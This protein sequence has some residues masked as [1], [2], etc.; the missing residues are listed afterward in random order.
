MWH[1]TTIVFAN[2]YHCITTLKYD[3]FGTDLRQ[4]VVTLPYCNC[5]AFITEKQSCST[6]IHVCKQ[7]CVYLGLSHDVYTS[8]C[9]HVPLKRITH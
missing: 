2:Y 4:A 6:C 5:G 1:K 8:T 9:I 3:A 7:N